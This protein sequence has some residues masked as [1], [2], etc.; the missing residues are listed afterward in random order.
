MKKT[1]KT[2]LALMAGAMTFTGC[3]S[4]ILENTPE[5]I[6]SA[7]KPMTFTAIQEGQG[8]ATRT[9]ISGTAIN[10][11]K[12]DK[13]SIFDGV[14]DKDGNLAREFVL[15]GEGGSAS[16]TFTGEADPAAT[17]Y[18]ALYPNVVSKSESK[19]PTEADA[20]AAAGGL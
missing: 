19:I 15:T 6:P 16:G 18:Y 20:K 12:S 8:D 9:A 11:T 3:T 4:D 2:M 5:Q 10:W 13:I 14:A 7:L 17:T 1:F